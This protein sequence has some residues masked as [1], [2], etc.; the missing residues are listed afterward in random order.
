MTEQVYPTREP[1]T[2]FRALV[3]ERLTIRR[4]EA[5][6]AVA[7]AAYRSV[8]DIARYQSWDTPFTPARA[9]RFIAALA[10]EHPDTTDQWFQFAVTASSTGRLL[11]DVAAGTGRDHRLARIGFTLAPDAQGHG[12]ATEAVTALVDYLVHTR[13]KHRVAADC[14]ARTTRSV[15]L[16]E[17]VGVRREAHHRRS[18]WWKGEWPD[19]FVY[20][21]LADEWRAHRPPGGR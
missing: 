3:T 13:G 16:L 11:G 15:A 6:D 19:E 8:P 9:A 10:T 14:D 18:V 17:R 21:V 2:G 12:F 5:A 7:F 20:A 1:D 4:F